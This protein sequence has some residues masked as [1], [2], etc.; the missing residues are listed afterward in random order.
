MNQEITSQETGSLTPIVFE[1]WELLLSWRNNPK[2]RS[3]SLNQEEINEEDHKSYIKRLVEREDRNQYIYV[4]GTSSV[5]YIRED[6]NDDGIELSYVIDPEQ[7]GKGYGKRMMRDYLSDRTGSFYL[8]IKESN[9]ASI[10]MAEAN[11]FTYD[12]EDG[13]SRIYK[14]FIG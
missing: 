4:D 5:G 8:H 2:V 10:K 13:E 1:D 6:F 7:T 12:S 3:A 14:L 9:I 11:G